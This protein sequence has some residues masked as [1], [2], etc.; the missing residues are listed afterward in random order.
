MML[1]SGRS[2]ALAALM[3]GA[4]CAPDGGDGPTEPVR[5]LAS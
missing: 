2:V 4:A 3:L 5:P 1:P